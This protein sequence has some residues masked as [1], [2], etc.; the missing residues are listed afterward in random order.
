MTL[1]ACGIEQLKLRR[2]LY[3]R[4]PAGYLIEILFVDLSPLPELSRD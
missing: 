3:F 1:A 2:S 4:D